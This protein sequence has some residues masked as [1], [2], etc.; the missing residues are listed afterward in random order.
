MEAFRTAGGRSGKVIGFAQKQEGREE[1]NALVCKRK[2]P[3]VRHRRY[4]WRSRASATAGL[5]RNPS[6]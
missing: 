1:W 3:A 4:N 6:P 5:A 2:N